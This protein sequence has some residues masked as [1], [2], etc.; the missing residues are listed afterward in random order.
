MCDWHI[1]DIC[2]IY[3]WH[4]CDWHI[5]NDV[6]SIARHMKEKQAQLHTGQNTK[7]RIWSRPWWMHI[8][9]FTIENCAVWHY[10]ILLLV[11][12]NFHKTE[13]QDSSNNPP[14]VS[15]LSLQIIYFRII[16][17]MYI[18]MLPACMFVNHVCVW[19][20]RMSEDGI[21]SP[22]TGITYR[23]LWVTRWLLRTELASFA[24]ATSAEPALQSQNYY[25]FKKRRRRKRSSRRSQ[26][27]CFAVHL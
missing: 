26:A 7:D 2:V 15:L 1:C 8:S 11:G 14:D 20:L 6:N 24:R 12:F 22:E 19:C 17:F 21:R 3:V 9:H 10:T 18:K 5:C 4:M 27:E 13:C 23:M 16:Y 25:F